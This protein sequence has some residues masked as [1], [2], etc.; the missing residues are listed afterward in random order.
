LI[1]I[2]EKM[3]RQGIGVLQFW[4]VAF[5]TLQFLTLKSSQRPLK[6]TFGFFTALKVT[7]RLIFLCTDDKL[8]VTAQLTYCF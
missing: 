8:K 2:L 4:K 1:P 6:V 7:A 5:Y 3:L